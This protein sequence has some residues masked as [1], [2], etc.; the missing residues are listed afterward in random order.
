MHFLHAKIAAKFSLV[1]LA[2]FLLCIGPIGCRRTVHVTKEM[3]W[4]CAPEEFKPALYAKPDDYVRFRFV[5]NPRCVEL[6]PSKNFCAEMK[7]V[8]RPIVKVDFEIWGRGQTVQG[9]KMIAVDGRP[10][11]H[12]GG[13]GYS[14]ANGYEGPSPIDNAFRSH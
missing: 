7:E 8:G 11:Q 14:A 2:F 6:E 1:A 9:Y 4:E 3:T 12:V 13:W 5:E 10:L